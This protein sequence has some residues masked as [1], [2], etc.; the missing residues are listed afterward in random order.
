[1]LVGAEHISILRLFAD[2][3]QVLTFCYIYIGQSRV[4]FEDLPP[5]FLP[6]LLETFLF[7]KGILRTSQKPLK[8]FQM[9]PLKLLVT[10]AQTW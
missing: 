1:M 8:S 5:N 9:I 10:S 7:L 3:C 4:L 2:I 6:S